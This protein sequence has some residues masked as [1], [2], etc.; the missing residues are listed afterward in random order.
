MIA[1]VIPNED[2]TIAYP[3]VL[4]DGERPTSA[5]DGLP[6][7]RR[8]TV[9]QKLEYAAELAADMEM[10][11]YTPEGQS[12]PWPKKRFIIR[13]ILTRM[14]YGPS[15]VAAGRRPA[16][17]P[18]GGTQAFRGYV[19]WKVREREMPGKV[20]YD[21][22]VPFIE[23]L[24]FMGF[25]EM[26]KRIRLH[27]EKVPFRD[28]SQFVLRGVEVIKG[29]GDPLSGNLSADGA[30][31][32]TAINTAIDGVGEATASNAIRALLVAF[33]A[34]AQKEVRQP[35]EVFRIP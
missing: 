29:R 27:P 19:D 15:Y 26:A 10:G 8:L 3:S 2:E 21:K 22:I 20:T 11:L 23:A 7:H 18:E 35:V 4:E 16:W 5:V 33:L 9:E 6:L 28:L 13:E 25:G 14:G 31:A 32:M 17:W 1:V 12:E 34:E 30:S 24:T